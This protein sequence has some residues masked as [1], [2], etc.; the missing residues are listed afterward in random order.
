MNSAATYS[1]LLGS[2]AAAGK[3]IVDILLALKAK[4]VFLN[5]IHHHDS[6]LERGAIVKYELLHGLEHDPAGL[7]NPH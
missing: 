1:S 3:S 7:E 5:E 4:H 2:P 6:L